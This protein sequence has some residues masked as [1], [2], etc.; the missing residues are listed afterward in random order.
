ML[1]NLM[2]SLF[3]SKCHRPNLYTRIKN[4]MPDIESKMHA[5]GLH[6][7]DPTRDTA[8]T[9]SNIKPRKLSFIETV[10]D[11][12]KFYSKRQI[13]LDEIALAGLHKAGFP[14]DREFRLIVENG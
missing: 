10:E 5:S 4:G 13:K 8:R 2:I 9:A 14:S 6:Y 3:V 7:L 12:K 11:R 1:P